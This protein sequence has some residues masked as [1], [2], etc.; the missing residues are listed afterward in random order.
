MCP[1]PRLNGIYHHHVDGFRIEATVN[2]SLIG[3]H[4]GADSVASRQ[5]GHSSDNAPLCSSVYSVID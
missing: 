2:D 3:K 5:G 1:Y 4:V